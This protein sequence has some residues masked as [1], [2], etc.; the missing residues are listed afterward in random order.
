VC[1]KLQD[2]SSLSIAE[3]LKD[4]RFLPPL[5]DSAAKAPPLSMSS[6]PALTYCVR[7]CHSTAYIHLCRVA[8]NHLAGCTS[9]LTPMLLPPTP[10]N[11]VVR[12]GA[13]TPLVAMLKL[14]D[15]SCLV[16]ASEALYNLASMASC[17]MAI[18]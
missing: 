9:A 15:D 17:K 7:H 10:Q 6:A 4:I 3:V 5:Y 18:K 11:E 8:H 14:Q 13:V 12:A 16:E 2:I 1:R